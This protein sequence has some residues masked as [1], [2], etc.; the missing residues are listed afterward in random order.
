MFKVSQQVTHIEYG[1]AEVL[2]RMKLED[3]K[4]TRYPSQLFTKQMQEQLLPLCIAFVL[5]ETE[6]L[7]NG[8][9][10]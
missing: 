4:V 9:P 10:H 2:D 1:G 3:D 7:K 5:G 6:I 8:F